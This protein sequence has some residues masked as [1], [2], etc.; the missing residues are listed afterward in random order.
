MNE[1]IEKLIGRLEERKQLHNRLIAY[2][3]KSGT[4]TE[5]FQHRKAVEVLDDAIEIVNQLAE[6]YNNESV[7]GDLISKKEVI[8]ELNG[9]YL[10]N[11]WDNKE[12][13]L[14]K[15]IGIVDHFPTAYNNGWIPC[16]VDLPIIPNS[17][18]VTKMCEN[19][20]NP[21]YETA[22]EIFWTSDKKWDCE[23]D[24]YCEWKVIAWQ[25]KI[26]PYQPKGE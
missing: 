7:K 25:N 4:I 23:R 1:F 9:I 2:E 26:A 21:I 8:T 17:Y 11:P 12:D 18:L 22:H 5:E 3:Q 16:S 14:E 15:A 19:D 24:E 13:I 10:D 20:G 6:E